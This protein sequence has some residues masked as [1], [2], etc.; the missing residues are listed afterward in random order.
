MHAWYTSVMSFPDHLVD[1]ILESLGPSEGDVFF[2]PYCGSGTSLVE[3]QRKGLD[4]FGIDANPSSVLASMVKTNW[5]IDPADVR[6]LIDRLSSEVSA[7]ENREDDPIVAYLEKSGMI[8]RGWIARATATQAA[9]IKRWIDR[10][11]S[12][13]PVYRFL[14]LA[15]ITTVVKDLANVKFGPELYCVSARD[16]PPDVVTHLI[17]RLNTMVADLESYRDVPRTVAQVRVG[18]A[19]DGRT[20]RTAARWGNGPAFIVT[21]PPYPTEHDYTR[22]SRLELVFMEAVVDVDSLRAIKRKMIRSHSKGIY[23]RD[24]DANVIDKFEPVK[25]IRRQIEELID[26]NSSG[27]EGQYPKV[28]SN[29]FGGMLRHFAAMTKYLPAG[30]RLAYVVGDEASYKGVHIPTARLLTEMIETYV[31]RLKLD[32]MNLWRTR[33]SHKDRQPLNEHIILLRVE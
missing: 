29:Y 10:T 12:G 1:S 26:E 2:D 5:S 21:S 7:L 18:D 20:L 17:G 8:E 30:S 27:F 32:Q 6:K 11:A 16:E 28:V 31:A 23:V 19:R 15:L 9:T 4:A 22:N 14:M 13:Q 33:R 25:N 24:R 3:A